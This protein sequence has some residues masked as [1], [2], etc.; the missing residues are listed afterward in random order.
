MKF[1]NLI[2]NLSFIFGLLVFISSCTKKEPIEPIIEPVYV[3]PTIPS[4]IL[5]LEPRYNGEAFE[6]GKNY[7]NHMDQIIKFEF[8]KFYLSDITLTTNEDSVVTISDVELF[9]LE[10]NHDVEKQIPVGM[11]KSISFAV[12]LDSLTNHDSDPN[13]FAAE[14]PLSYAQNTHWGWASLYKFM[15]IEGRVD[16]V[17]SDFLQKAFSYHT[18]FDELY[19]PVTIETSFEVDTLENNLTLILN[20]D[21]VFDAVSSVDMFNENASHALTPIARKLSDNI[22]DSFEIN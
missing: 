17:E 20:I 13:T 6:F 5:S 2:F 21:G 8:F 14:H 18:G 1:C 15:Q 7:T 3:E 22:A 9:D 4:F 16:E 11:Y 19:R 10:K 12:G